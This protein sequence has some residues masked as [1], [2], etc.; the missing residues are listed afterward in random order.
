MPP[1]SIQTS[2]ISVQT[3]QV[4]SAKVFLRTTSPFVEL[5]SSALTTF[6]ALAPTPTYRLVGAARGAERIG[7]ITEINHC[8]YHV[9]EMRIV[10]DAGRRI[11][12]FG[13][14][15]FT[16]LT[17]GRYVTLRLKRFI[18]IAV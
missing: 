2:Q 11:A 12:G 4:G 13:A 18:A 9:Q 15:A 8:G 14:K 16:E 1:R 6:D 7:V 10:D 5:Q 17:G 3:R